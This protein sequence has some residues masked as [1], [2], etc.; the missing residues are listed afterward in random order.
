MIQKDIILFTP[1]LH[2]LTDEEIQE[3]QAIQAGYDITDEIR[4]EKLN[5]AFAENIIKDCDPL[6]YKDA[7]PQYNNIYSLIRKYPPSSNKPLHQFDEDNK[8]QTCIQL[9]RLIH[10][11]S[12]NLNYAVRYST[13]NE[14]DQIS[15]LN[16]AFGKG[17]FLVQFNNNPRHKNWLSLAN[18]KQLSELMKNFD[19][20]KLPQRVRKALFYY[21]YAAWTQY[22]DMKWTLIST[23]LDALIH[24]DRDGSTKQFKQRVSKLACDLGIQFKENQEAKDAYDQRSTIIHTEHMATM[25]SSTLILYE[26]MEDVLRK[27]LLEAIKNKNIANIFSTDDNIRK[28]DTISHIKDI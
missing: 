25:D 19:I 22:I 14:K 23:A 5:H 11:T 27:I 13:E 1:F 7:Y 9:S 8:L 28:L 3:L 21:E 2:S 10:P 16:P 20:T 4:L 18:L 24:T 15:P 17:A 26:K 12:I 6:A